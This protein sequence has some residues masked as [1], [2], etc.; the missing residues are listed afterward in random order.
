MW[1]KNCEFHVTQTPQSFSFF[2]NFSFWSPWMSHMG[3]F[4]SLLSCSFIVCLLA[5]SCILSLT[6]FISTFFFV[7]LKKNLVTSQRGIFISTLCVYNSSE[8]CL[9]VPDV[10]PLLSWVWGFL[11]QSRAAQLEVKNL[12]CFVKC[13][14]QIP[15]PIDPLR[16]GD[17]SQRNPAALC[18]GPLTLRLLCMQAL[19]TPT[20]ALNTCLKFWWTFHERLQILFSL[21]TCLRFLFCFAHSSLSK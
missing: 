16:R 18:I 6:F 9:G 8:G 10:S 12:S 15:S 2:Y 4:I 1:S 19:P 13:C 21:W 7:S 17:Y 14:T 11:L 5:W 20:A 3:H